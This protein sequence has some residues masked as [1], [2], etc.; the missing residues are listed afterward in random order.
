MS[1]M[2]KAEFL[3]YDLSEMGRWGLTGEISILLEGPWNVSLRSPFPNKRAKTVRWEM[4]GTASAKCLRRRVIFVACRC[5]WKKGGGGE[6]CL[7]YVDSL[8]RKIVGH[9]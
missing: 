4:D 7:C 1:E 2:W 9:D 5:S 6:H 8:G 3:T